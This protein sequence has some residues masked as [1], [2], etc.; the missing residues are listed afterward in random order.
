[1]LDVPS[2]KHVVSRIEVLR[3]VVASG[4]RGV[5]PSAG[6]SIAV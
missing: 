5:R 6:V 1:V 3:V 4:Q 2:M